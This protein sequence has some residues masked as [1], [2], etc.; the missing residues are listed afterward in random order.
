MMPTYTAVLWDLDG[1][2]T[3]PKE[4]ITNCVRYALDGLGIPAPSANELEWVIGPPL[5][6]SFEK[7]VGEDPRFVT[8]ALRLYRERFG[9]IGLYENRLYDGIGELLKD[10]AEAGV[11]NILATSKPEV[12]ATRILSHFGLE[13]FFFVAI[14]S[15]LDGTNVEKDDLIQLAL[16]RL[17]DTP[18]SKIVM[19]GD[20]K[21]DIE[22][23][24]RHGIDSAAV[25]YG[26]GSK[27][28]LEAARPTALIEDVRQLR[29]FL[30][31]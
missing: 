20:R 16:D 24:R 30:L 1:T 18:T 29:E 25:M 9:T 13:P 6:R 15:N 7:L 14:G 19:V 27:E 22:G 10:L 17:S 8:E 31:T 21:Y 4:G 11:K 2:L 28:E 23:A 5:G 12:Y 3:D 26:Y